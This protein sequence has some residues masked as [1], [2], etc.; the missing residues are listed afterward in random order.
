M[1]LKESAARLHVHPHTIQYRFQRIEE[2]S[3]LNPRGFVDLHTLIV[4]I[5]LD[6]LRGS[7]APR[8]VAG[9]QAN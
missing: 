4:A 2:P 6:E 9:P 5:A 7:E 1:R 3:D 8:G